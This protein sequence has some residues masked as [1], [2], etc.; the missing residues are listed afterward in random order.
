MRRCTAEQKH[1]LFQQIS[2]FEEKKISFV[3]KV[4]VICFAVLSTDSLARHFMD[5]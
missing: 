4:V 1:A 5:L 3:N 2:Y